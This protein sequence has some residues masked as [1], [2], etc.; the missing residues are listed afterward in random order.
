MMILDIDTN[1]EVGEVLDQ[2][3]ACSLI[4]TLKVFEQPNKSMPHFSSDAAKEAKKV[5]K[6]IKALKLVIK[7]YGT[8]ENYDNT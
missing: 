6:I 2:L 3:V 4:D 8:P 1:L 7:L 5:E